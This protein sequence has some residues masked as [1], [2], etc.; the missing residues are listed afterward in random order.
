MKPTVVTDPEK[1]I[2]EG[3]LVEGVATGIA[4]Q[5]RAILAVEIASGPPMPDMI[6]I[7]ADPENGTGIV[8]DRPSV[9][10]KVVS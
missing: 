1:P 4:G 8:R 5:V 9:R 2:V 6:V 10:H 3:D 7:M